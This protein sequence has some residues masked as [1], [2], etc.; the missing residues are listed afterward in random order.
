MRWTHRKVWKKTGSAKVIK[1]GKRYQGK[2][3]RDG[4][5]MRLCDVVQEQERG[6]KADKAKGMSEWGGKGR[7]RERTTR[8]RGPVGHA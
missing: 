5:R 8:R 2:I 7:K 6:D 3:V 4:Y 1:T